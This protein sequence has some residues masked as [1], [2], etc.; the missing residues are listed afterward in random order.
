MIDGDPTFGVLHRANHVCWLMHC[1]IDHR[2]GLDDT[3]AFD[4]NSILSRIRAV[5]QAYSLAVYADSLIDQK[6]L[7]ATPGGQAS[8]GDNFLNAFL[9]HCLFLIIQ[10]NAMLS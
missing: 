7:R 3:D 4:F 8:A 6:L 9:F 2:F 1:D 5:T 10:G